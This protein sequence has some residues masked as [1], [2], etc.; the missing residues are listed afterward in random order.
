MSN[1][2]LRVYV[3]WDG[4]DA[5]AYEVCR[6]SL[7]RH[8]S[9]P[10][11]IIS[12]KDWELRRKG[13]YWRASRTDSSGQRWDERDGKPF[14]T[15]FSF[16]RFCVPALESFGDD[17]VLF[18]DAD[19]MW[20]ADIADLLAQADSQKGVMC[21]QH[22]HAPLELEKMGGLVQTVYRRKNWSSLMLLKPSRCT[23]LTKYAVNNQT[24]QWL[25]AMCWAKEEEIGCLP[26]EWNWLEGWSS[27]NIDPK[28]VHYTRGTP[29]MP[30]TEDA[31]YAEEWRRYA[32]TLA[33]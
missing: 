11:E 14:S 20:R 13:L 32:G 5:L 24:G 2:P 10:V 33:G 15:D 7:L 26:D 19:M 31:G 4:R 18:M 12:V 16:T 17:W 21:V 28:I 22:R 29:D 3:G 8:A 23:E 27:P 6:K 1:R 30:G 25:H 9:I